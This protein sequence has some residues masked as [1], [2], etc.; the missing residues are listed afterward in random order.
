M[1]SK[2][3]N[4]S[5][6]C[7]ASLSPV[8]WPFSKHPQLAFEKGKEQQIDLIES[9]LNF[10]QAPIWIHIVSNDWR[11]SQFVHWCPSVQS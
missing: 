11:Y 1:S 3:S 8:C 9:E 5:S 10:A 4:T 2:R 6:Q 7:T